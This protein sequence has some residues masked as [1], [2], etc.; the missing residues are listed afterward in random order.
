MASQ[1]CP[2]RKLAAQLIVV[3]GGE[4]AA[5]VHRNVVT[6]RPDQVVQRNVEQSRLEIPQ[7]DID[8]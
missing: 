7:C 2:V 4:A 5:T 1:F 3:V 8:G 6:C